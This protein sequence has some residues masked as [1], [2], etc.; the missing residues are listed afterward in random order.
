MIGFQGTVVMWSFKDIGHPPRHPGQ[1]HG[2]KDA[3]GNVCQGGAAPCGFA[4][5]GCGPSAPGPPPPPPPPPP[6]PGHGGSCATFANVS[7]LGYSCA[8]NH[9]LSDGT[10]QPGHCGAGLCTDGSTSALC[11]LLDCHGG[12]YAACSTAAVGRCDAE[13]TCHGF[14]LYHESWRGGKAQFF[15]SGAGGLVSEVGGWSAYTK[16]TP[17]KPA[18]AADAVAMPDTAMPA[19]TRASRPSHEEMLSSGASLPLTVSNGQ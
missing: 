12:D 19:L 14:A 15:G 4:K 16:P 6:R 17:T 5:H 10:K 11:A 3:W 8:D 1:L 2:G 13:P 18:A 7:A 9:C